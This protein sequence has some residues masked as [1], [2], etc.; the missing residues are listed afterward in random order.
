[1]N[2]WLLALI[3]VP[4]LMPYGMLVHGVLTDRFD[5]GS[6][7][8]AHRILFLALSPFLYLI[9]AAI[10]ATPIYWGWSLVL[11]ASG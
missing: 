8:A 6:N 10:W 1:M 3:F 7:E 2:W 4:P 5:I 11:W 9:L